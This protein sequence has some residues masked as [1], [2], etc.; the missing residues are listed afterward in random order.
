MAST[1]RCAPQSEFA[2]SQLLAPSA[3][4]A[5]M[6]V[7]APQTWA[8][9]RR[10]F[11]S[12]VLWEFYRYFLSLALTPAHFAVTIFLSREKVLEGRTL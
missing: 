3:T 12:N 8:P 7:P 4:P 9:Q 6:S 10:Y 11:V 1:A 5:K 2:A